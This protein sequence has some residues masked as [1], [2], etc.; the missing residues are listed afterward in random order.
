MADN[1]IKVRARVSDTLHDIKAPMA[2]IK[3]ALL[4]LRDGVGGKT[5]EKQGK[6]IGIALDCAE[7]IIR[8]T[9]NILASKS[10]AREMKRMRF[11]IT[12]AAK[13]I[14]GS[15]EVLAKA[16]SVKLNG[17]VPAKTIEVWGDPDRLNEAISNLIENAIK[18]NKPDGSVDFSL[19]EDSDNIIISVRDTGIGIDEEDL[20][21]VFDRHYRSRRAELNGIPGTG[22]GL[23]I[24][25]EIVDM[26][27]GD[28]SVESQG[29]GGGT[30]FT[31]VLPKDL[32][33]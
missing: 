11:S 25:R 3:E 4:L 17:S 33:G 1:R 10:R 2:T 16:K 26:H 9:D 13:A 5:S 18:Y 22:L 30:K 6:Y 21:R 23:S 14:L 27:K 7:R 32:R 24:V 8:M 12:D 29:P 19:G 15:L 28:I 20:G 31:V